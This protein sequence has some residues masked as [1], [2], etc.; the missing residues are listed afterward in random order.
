MTNGVSTRVESIV[1]A[2][3]GQKLSSESTSNQKNEGKNRPLCTYCGKLGHIIDK[4]YKLHGFPT[5]F[6]FKNKPSMAHQLSSGQILESLPFASPLHN[7]LAFTSN[8]Y[9]QLLAVIGASNSSLAATSQAKEVPIANVASSSNTAMASIDFS[10]NVFSAQVV[11]RRAYGRHTWVLDTSATDHF[12]C[13]VD[14]LLPMQSLVQ[15]P[16]GESAQVT[17]IGTVVLSSSLTLKNVLCVASFTFNILSVST[18][19]QSQPYCLVFL[20][21]YCFVQDLLF[22]K[23]IGVGKAIDGLYLLQCESLQ[24]TPSSSLADFLD[25]HKISAAFLPFSVATSTNCNSSFL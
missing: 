21:A 13:S 14:L 3:K 22:W 17:H 23:T 16:N 11:N 4:C 2:A 6:K 24:H 12:F 8:Q 15:L 1:L 7:H 20:S 25:A 5:G 19:T 10:H 9:Q 18:I